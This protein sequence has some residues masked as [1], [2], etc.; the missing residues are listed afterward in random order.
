MNK[1]PTE[2]ELDLAVET[3]IDTYKDFEKAAK[4]LMAIMDSM[5]K[6][7]HQELEALSGDSQQPHEFLIQIIDE[8]GQIGENCFG[9]KCVVE[10]EKKQEGKKHVFAQ[11]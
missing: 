9:I 6:Q 11:I 8:S 5:N 4:N 10:K 7:R 1:E 3:F 2:D